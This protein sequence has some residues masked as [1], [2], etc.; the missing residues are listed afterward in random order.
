[1]TAR[2]EGGYDDLRYSGTDE[3]AGPQ[4]VVDAM[5]AARAKLA[6][7]V[8]EEARRKQQALQARFHWRLWE[9]EY[10]RTQGK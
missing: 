5:R 3:R 6:D 8:Q 7:P 2:A 1:M 9:Q 4:G 10:D